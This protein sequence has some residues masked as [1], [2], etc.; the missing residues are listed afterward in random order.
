MIMSCVLD[1]YTI[2]YVVCFVYMFMYDIYG[3]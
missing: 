1:M 2:L 3:V